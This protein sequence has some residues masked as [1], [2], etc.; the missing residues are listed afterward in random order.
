MTPK[1]S[2]GRKARSRAKSELNLWAAKL[3]RLQAKLSRERNKN[4]GGNPSS[5]SK[6]Q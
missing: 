1:V 2:R 4:R 6:E 3:E 5:S